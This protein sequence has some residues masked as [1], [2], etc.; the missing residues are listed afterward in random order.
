[1][2][3]FFLNNCRAKIGI[4]FSIVSAA[5]LRCALYLTYFLFFGRNRKALPIKKK[6]QIT[7]LRQGSWILKLLQRVLHSHFILVFRTHENI[8][9]RY[10][11]SSFTCALNVEALKYWTVHSFMNGV[12]R[13]FSQLCHRGLFHLLSRE[14]TPSDRN[15][16]LVPRHW[17]SLA[18]LFASS[19]DNGTEP[20]Y[21]IT[22]LVPLKTVSSAVA[23]SSLLPQYLQPI[24]FLLLIPVYFITQKKWGAEQSQ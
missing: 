15:V 12:L 14:M 5:Q 3:D 11:P 1:M 10:F 17:Y 13:F 23:R 18:S 2:P 22:A 7:F 9:L 6:V 4:S 19:G 16:V 20:E 21:R 8:W 24:S